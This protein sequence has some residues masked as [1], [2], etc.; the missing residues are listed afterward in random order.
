MKLLTKQIEA[1]LMKSPLYSQEK[2]KRPAVIVK[3]FTPDSNWT[4]YATEGEKQED[5]DCRFFGLV[6]GFESELGYFMLSE[7][8]SAKG[9]LGLPIE[10]DRYFEGYVLD[11]DAFP[12]KPIK[13]V[14]S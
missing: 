3:F 2:N 1:R 4:W 8:E 7:L 13:A 9:L 11:M 5:G 10:R 14:K 6:E 12:V